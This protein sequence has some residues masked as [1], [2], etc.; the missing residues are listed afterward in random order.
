MGEL[1]S[2]LPDQTYPCL[3]LND[4]TLDENLPVSEHYP[5]QSN[6]TQP[7]ARAGTLDSLPLELIHKILC[8]LDV[9]T[10]SD[11]RATNRRA[12]ELVDTLPQYKAIITHARNALRG[13]LSIQTGRWITCRTL[14]QKLC[15][16][17]CEHCGD[18]AGYLYLLTCKRVCFLC[19]TKNDLY[20]P[21]PPGRACRKFG[22]TRQI[23][24]TLPLMTVIPGI[25]SPNE[26]KAPKRVLV[27]YEASLYAGI[28]LH[29]SRNAMNQYIAD[30]EAE[31]ATRQ[32]TS[33]GRR[34]RVP[35]A[36]H[37]D[38]ES[39]NPFRFVAIS[40]V[41]QLV[42]T[43]RD[44]ERGFH[45]A[46]CRKSMDLPS[47]CRR[48]FTTASFEAHLKQFGRIKHENHHLD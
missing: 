40:F 20:L 15:T 31:L 25:Y 33:T 28:K 43:S 12:T 17:Q 26:K 45:C 5:L 34:R 8:Q 6:R 29:G 19:F 42:K 3:N 21:L 32:S 14:Y 9:R 4:H 2:S 30:R 48:K 10:L 22:L 37:F 7:V 35:V 38:G 1:V 24:Q 27:D 23:V 16:P 11:F 46:G 47:H 13:I 36:D 41:P 44:V 39:G 18:F